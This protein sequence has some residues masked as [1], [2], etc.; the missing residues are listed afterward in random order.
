MVE[1][2]IGLL[3]AF[4]FDGIKTVAQVI[5]YYEAVKAELDSGPHPENSLYFIDWE[6]KVGDKSEKIPYSIA[7]LLELGQ[8]TP[9]TDQEFYQSELWQHDAFLKPDIAV[10]V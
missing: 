1:F 7:S 6:A 10:E 9:P 3:E 4:F 8:F 2:D 5:E